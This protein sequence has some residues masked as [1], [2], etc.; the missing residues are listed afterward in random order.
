MYFT[1]TST[2]IPLEEG[3]AYIA[4]FPTITYRCVTFNNRCVFVVDY[5]IYK[6]TNGCIV[7]PESDKQHYFGV[8][9]KEI[10]I[11]TPQP[12]Q[13]SVGRKK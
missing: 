12:R 9:W 5:D 7:Y 6:L 10:T 4:E 8:Y 11:D 3:T 2:N 1:L 13:R